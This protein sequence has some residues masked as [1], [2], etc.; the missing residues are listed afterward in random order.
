KPS[1]IRPNSLTRTATELTLTG[2]NLAQ[3]KFVELRK[4]GAVPIRAEAKKPATPTEVKCSLAIPQGSEGPW[5]AVANDGI[6]DYQV[7]GA[8]TIQNG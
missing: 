6:K 5:Q 1:G 2:E 3:I 8:V 4:E 7:P